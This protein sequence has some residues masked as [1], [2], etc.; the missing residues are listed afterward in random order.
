MEVY[1]RNFISVNYIKNVS[2][3]WGQ[4]WCRNMLKKIKFVTQKFKPKALDI[5]K[6]TSFDYECRRG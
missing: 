1:D 4:N 6:Q 5:K 3:Y 2:A